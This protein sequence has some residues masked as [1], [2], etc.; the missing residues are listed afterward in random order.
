MRQTD[1][2]PTVPRTDD[3]PALSAVLGADV[4]RVAHALDRLADA[5]WRQRI[6][7]QALADIRHDLQFPLESAWEAVLDG[8]FPRRATSHAQARAHD[9]LSLDGLHGA[10]RVGKALDALEEEGREGAPVPGLAKV[11]KAYAELDSVARPYAWISGRT[12]KPG[13]PGVVGSD[14]PVPAEPTLPPATMR[15]QA[16]VREAMA[17]AMAG[18]REGFVGE[19]L[20]ACERDAAALEEASAG[21]RGL[22]EAMGGAAQRDWPRE[23]RDAAAVHGM[24]IVRASRFGEAL[25][26]RDPHRSTTERHPN[27]AARARGF[28]EREADDA[29]RLCVERNVE[30]LASVVESMGGAE[31]VLRSARIGLD[32]VTTEFSV[33]FPGRGGFR[34]TNSIVRGE[35]R[36]GTGYTQF[37]ARFHDVV[38]P[39]GTRLRGPSEAAVR[40]AFVPGAVEDEATSGPRM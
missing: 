4:H 34:Y 20:K 10:A 39:D 22:R 1:T 32:G 29:M 27:G 9:A 3:L 33:A 19:L 21:L 36:E 7:P 23:A 2:R 35:T 17:S 12:G 8:A 26:A 18:L 5:V 15:A 11:R 24:A 30:K 25:V 38:R 16:Q 37:P 31:I 14:I 13:K 6:K 40:K 28:C